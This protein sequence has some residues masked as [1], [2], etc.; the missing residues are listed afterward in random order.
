MKYRFYLLLFCFFAASRVGFGQGPPMMQTMTIKTPHGNVQ[1]SYYTGG[2]RYYYGQG[3]ISVKH[4]FQIILK[5]DSNFTSRTRIDLSDEKNQSLTVKSNGD[6]RKIFPSET[7]SI[8]CL[9]PSGQKLIGLPADSCW[10]FKVAIG[11]IN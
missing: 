6:K 8:S 1:H 9:S 11:K 7:K 5:N 2:Q 10:L 3:N 4:E